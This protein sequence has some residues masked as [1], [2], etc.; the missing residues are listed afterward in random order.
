VLRS[1][2]AKTPSE[3]ELPARDVIDLGRRDPRCSCGYPSDH[4]D[5]DPRHQRGRLKLTRI[6]HRPVRVNAPVFGSYSSAVAE[7]SPPRSNEPPATST[8]PSGSRVTVPPEC[9]SC[10]EPVGTNWPV[11]GSNSSAVPTSSPPAMSYL[12]VAESNGHCPDWPRRNARRQRQLPSPGFVQ[13]GGAV[14][15]TSGDKDS[16]VCSRVAVCPRRATFMCV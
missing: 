7:P 16:P 8:R 2:L 6:I 13:L 11:V 5:P 3:L 12:S 15:V 10:I 1:R 9:G 14:L 4:Q